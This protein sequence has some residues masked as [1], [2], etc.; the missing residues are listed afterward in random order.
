MKK[1]KIEQKKNGEYHSID[2]SWFLKK[3]S[4]DMTLLMTSSNANSCQQ[5]AVDSYI[6]S[7]SIRCPS[8]GLACDDTELCSR[9]LQ[10]GRQYSATAHLTAFPF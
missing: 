3:L 10:V 6:F 1:K 5:Q 2:G 9:K 4:H 7:P 8:L